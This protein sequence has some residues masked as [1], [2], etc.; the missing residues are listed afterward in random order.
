MIAGARGRNVREISDPA[1]SGLTAGL[2]IPRGDPASVARC[3]GLIEVIASFQ[4]GV[5]TA[6]TPLA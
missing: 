4:A 3:P 5:K 6:T 1:P 2:L